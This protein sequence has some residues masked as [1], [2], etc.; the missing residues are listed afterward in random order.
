MKK[1]KEVIFKFRIISNYNDWNNRRLALKVRFLTH[2]TE[3]EIE[4][5][6]EH[7]VS[8]SGVE[9][10]EIIPDKS[11]DDFK[12][13]FTV[14]KDYASYR[15]ELL[16]HMNKKEDSILYMGIPEVINE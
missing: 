9:N 3:P 6:G 8:I 13:C 2:I 7:F 16:I 4:I 12:R 5:R 10:Y 15:H 1:S 14:K 11:S